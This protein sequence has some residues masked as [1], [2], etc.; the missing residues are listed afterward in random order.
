[1]GL[2]CTE[3]MS[4][5]RG[6]ALAVLLIHRFKSQ[7]LKLRSSLLDVKIHFLQSPPLV[8]TPIP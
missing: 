5:T 7:M 6:T 2:N 8:Q 3:A 4:R 1:M